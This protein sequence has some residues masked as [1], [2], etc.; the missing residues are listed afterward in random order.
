[1]VHCYRL[2]R[3]FL[4]T[5]FGI[6]GPPGQ[7]GARVKGGFEDFSRDFHSFP[8]FGPSACGVGVADPNLWTENFVDVSIPLM[9]SSS[10]TGFCKKQKKARF[11]HSHIFTWQS[12]AKASLIYST[13]ANTFTPFTRKVAT[14]LV[15]ISAPQKIFRPPPLKFPA[16]TL[17]APRPP[18]PPSPE[19]PPP[20]PWDF[21]INPPWR[22]RLLLLLPRAEK[23]KISET[24]TKL[25]I[26]CNDLG[27]SQDIA[28][29]PKSFSTMLVIITVPL[30][31]EKRA[32]P[33]LPAW[34]P[35]LF[36]PLLRC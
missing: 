23:Q 18:T 8:A 17:L 7:R 3:N 36:R 31:L 26:W 1:M 24:S 20:T 28:W 5:K 6:L 15:G 2:N 27:G 14:N 29:F 13:H 25:R 19:R 16:D 33:N 22:L 10:F 4:S 30:N 11:V 35:C 34:Y 32:L 21:Q 12:R 9:I